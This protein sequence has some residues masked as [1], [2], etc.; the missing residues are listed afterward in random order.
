MP[1][2]VVVLLDPGL[3]SCDSAGVETFLVNETTIAGLMYA[4]GDVL[5]IRLSTTGTDSTALKAK[6]CK[7]TDTEP[8]SWQ[9]SASDSPA[10][11]SVGLWTY[12]SSSATAFP[13]LT[14][15]NL[16]VYKASTL[17]RARHYGHAAHGRA[18]LDRGRLA[19][20]RLAPLA[21]RGPGRPRPSV[22]E[23]I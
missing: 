16:R 13:V 1:A 12:V 3:P 6:L 9:I 23:T 22:D 5:N 18:A 14:V 10:A 7:S 2:V 11:G 4:A 15:D 21:A 19:R 20:S 8:A 17:Q